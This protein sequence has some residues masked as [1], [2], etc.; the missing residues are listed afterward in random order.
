MRRSSER[1]RRSKE[2]RDGAARGSGRLGPENVLALDLAG[3][4]LEPSR[5]RL[6]EA[7]IAPIPS[8]HISLLCDVREGARRHEAWAVFQTRYR[9]V[10]V[11]WCL[12]RGLSADSAEDLTQDVMLK[13]FQQLP[14]H[15]HDPSR[16]QFRG[17]LKAVVNN[18]LTD[19][20][21]RQRRRPERGD[22]GYRTSGSP[23][24][25]PTMPLSHQVRNRCQ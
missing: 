1:E 5:S 18:A 8:T 22:G 6:P 3:S 24:T 19:F 4:M 15:S 21:R 12:R 23:A 2:R 11:G 7:T 16:G 14:Q 13:L 17:W 25:E 10:I 9:G 20:W